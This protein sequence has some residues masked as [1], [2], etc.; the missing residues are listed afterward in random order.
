MTGIGIGKPFKLRV[1]FFIFADVCKYRVLDLLLLGLV[2]CL[3]TD[4]AVSV[5]V[6][7]S[8]ILLDFYFVRVLILQ[9]YIAH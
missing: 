4:S 5:S 2:E 3:I 1:V 9:V 6:S 7:S 8:H